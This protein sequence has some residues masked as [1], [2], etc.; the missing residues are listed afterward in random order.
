MKKII[1]FLFIFFF[2]GFAYSQSGDYNILDKGISYIYHVKFDSASFQFNEFINKYPHSPEG[3]FYNAMLEWW[4]INLD[5]NNESNDENFYLK[6]NKILE[7]CNNLLEQNEN[8]FNAIFYKGGILGY[9]GLLKSIRESWLKAAEDGREAL[10]LLEHASQIQPDNKDSQMGI[11]IYNYFADYVPQKYPVLMPLLL[12]FKKGDKQKGFLQIKETAMNSRFA[13]TEAKFILSYIY[14]NFEKNFNESEYYSKKLFEEF[15]ENPIFEKYVCTSYS[16][17]SKNEEAIEG[18]KKILEKGV[19]KQTGYDNKNIQ[20]EANYYISISYFNLGRVKEAEVYLKNCE[21]I[22]KSLD[23]DESSS[24]TANTYLMLGCCFDQ[25]GDRNTAIYYYD[26][27]LNMKN[28]DTHPQA[29]KFKK[30]GYK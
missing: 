29:E 28:F 17:L 24:F 2:Y 3:Y 27:V 18:W 15:P 7:V 20:R 9:R 6:V 25:K 8:D 30:A 19:N 23:K 14:L 26:K 21:E 13:K 22:N 10:N 11:G 16:G 12:I 5:K 1:L 4:K